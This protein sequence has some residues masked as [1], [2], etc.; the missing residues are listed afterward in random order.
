M[1]SSATLVFNGSYYHSQT[2]GSLIGLPN[3]WLNPNPPGRSADF[4]ANSADPT[5]N[6]AL[7]LDRNDL[8]K[9]PAFYGRI[10]SNTD[11]PAALSAAMT[12]DNVLFYM[13]AG[14]TQNFPQGDL[15]AM[16]MQNGAGPSLLK[17]EQLALFNGSGMTG[18]TVYTL[19]SVPGS[20]LAGIET[21]GKA[22]YGSSYYPNKDTWVETRC[23]TSTVISMVPSADGCYPVEIG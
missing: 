6:W 22:R 3:I 4:V 10:P 17:M 21:I 5:N 13:M 20:G 18:A 1:S 16:L 15:F 2:D 8:T 23:V 9:T 11:V 12:T 7:V 14:F 19:V